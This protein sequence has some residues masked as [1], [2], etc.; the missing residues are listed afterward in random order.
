MEVMTPLTIVLGVGLEPS[1]LA[2]QGSVWKSGGYIVTSA[3]SI[4]EA[5]D[6]F[7]VGDFDLVLLG[8]SL[9][10]ENKERLAFLIRASGSRTPVVCIAGCSGED[11]P[12]ADATLKSDSSELITG[13]GTVM[14]RMAR[15][16]AAPTT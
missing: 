12:F 14:A 8:C 7:R 5:I 10:L 3:G 11:D 1:L 4:K 16:R 6:H 15:N 13:M 9:S 2:T